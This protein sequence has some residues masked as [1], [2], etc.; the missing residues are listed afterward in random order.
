LNGGEDAFWVSSLH[1]GFGIN[2]G[3]CDVAV[4]GDLQI[5]NRSEHA[6]VEALAREFGEEAFESDLQDDRKSANLHC[7][8]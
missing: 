5:N 7:R 6:A 1:E 8:S 2:V 4:D 3:L